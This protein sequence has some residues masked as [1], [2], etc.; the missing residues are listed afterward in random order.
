MKT[1]ILAFVLFALAP[2][3][4][5]AQDKGTLA[6][7][8]EWKV[9]KSEEAPP[10]T[11]MHFGNDGK[12]TLTYVIE[13]KARVIAG[14]YSLVGNQ[15]TMKLAHDGRERVEVRT[16]KKLTESVLI[17]EDKNKKLEELQR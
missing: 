15:L 6:G 12:V 8:E 14:T 16:V 9:V 13:G 17:T 2:V 10:G 3:A 4:L 11:K 1:P 5:L 7:N